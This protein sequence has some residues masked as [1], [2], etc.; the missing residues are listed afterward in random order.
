LG[1]WDE[2]AADFARAWAARPNEAQAGRWLALAQLA[3][4]KEDAYRQS[5]AALLQRVAATPDAAL[6][7][8]AFAAVPGS[9]PA[10]AVMARIEEFAVRQRLLVTATCTLRPGAVADPTRLLFWDERA[11]P[12]LR[13][14]VLCRAGRHE[15]AARLLRPVNSVWA[16][17]YLALA[18]HGLG[19]PAEAKQAL[20][21]AVQWLAQP[22]SGDPKQTNAAALSWE[23]RLEFASLRK[24]AEDLLRAASP[25]R[26]PPG[27]RFSARVKSSAFPNR[28]TPA[29]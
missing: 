21:K 2:A 26:P 1:Q 13:G 29:A 11:D 6:A 22:N 20:D 28:G 10:A 27:A 8:L 7:G 23:A 25:D 24:E 14:Y 3:S 16:L 5:C 9:V 15:E 18:E 19:R 12:V 4:G 17:L